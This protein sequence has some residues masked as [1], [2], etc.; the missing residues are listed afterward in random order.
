MEFLVEF[1]EIN[2]VFERHFKAIIAG[3]KATTLQ[4]NTYSFFRENENGQ[5]CMESLSFGKVKMTVNV[6]GNEVD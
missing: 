4:V 5:S 3:C 1:Q 2:Y 6:Q